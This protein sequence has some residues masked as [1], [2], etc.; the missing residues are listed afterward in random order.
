MPIDRLLGLMIMNHLSSDG[1]MKTKDSGQRSGLPVDDVAHAVINVLA[2]MPIADPRRRWARGQE[3]LRR[4]V[5]SDDIFECENVR[6]EIATLG[7]TD[8]EIV[9]SC[10]PEV[11]RD[12]GGDWEDDSLSFAE[13]SRASSRLH[14]F[15]R[16]LDEEAQPAMNG[17]GFS[18]L[19]VSLKREDH[20]IGPAVLAKQLRRTGNHVS[21][22]SNC[23]VDDIIN[24]VSESSYDCLM[25]SLASLV[26]ARTAAEAVRRIHTLTE[27]RFPIYLGGAAL[28]YRADLRDEV[29][30]DLVTN[31]IAVALEHMRRHRSEFMRG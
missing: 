1:G 29:G 11:A 13:V 20:I 23:T 15:C 10:I 7:M 6:A 28:E 25:I 31:D 21:L 17:D 12:L 14:S 5:L 19:L 22:M 8:N 26:G 24:R 30:A 2:E 9:D 18:I 3:L 27:R 4:A 16:H